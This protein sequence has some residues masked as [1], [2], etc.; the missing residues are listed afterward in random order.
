MQ[1]PPMMR[2]PPPMTP[3]MPNPYMNPPMQHQHQPPK[4]QKS[5]KLLR[6]FNEAETSTMNEEYAKSKQ[7]AMHLLL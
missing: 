6:V 4:T 3:G 7:E 1:P 2:P 5:V